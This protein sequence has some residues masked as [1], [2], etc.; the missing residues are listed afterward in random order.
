MLRARTC[1]GLPYSV[2]HGR[3]E[4]TSETWGRQEGG[5]GDERHA[6]PIPRCLHELPLSAPRYVHASARRKRF[7]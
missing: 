2:S 6:A 3:K 4:A 7:C 5:P 1:G